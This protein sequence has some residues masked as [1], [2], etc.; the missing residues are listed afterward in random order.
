MDDQ[1]MHPD[2]KVQRVIIRHNLRIRE[3]LTPDFGKTCDD[4]GF[5]KRSV[6]LCQAIL[7]L[8]RCKTLQEQPLGRGAPAIAGK[9]LTIGQAGRRFGVGLRHGRGP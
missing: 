6:N 8:I 7:H 4:S 5:G 9:L 2:L 3:R 1:I